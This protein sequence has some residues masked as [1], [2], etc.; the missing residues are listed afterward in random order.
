MDCTTLAKC[1]TGAGG[2]VS[3][4]DVSMRATTPESEQSRRFAELVESEP[5]KQ[6]LYVAQPVA[7]P[8]SNALT[9]TMSQFSSLDFSSFALNKAQALTQQPAGGSGPG[10]EYQNAAREAIAAQAEILRTVMMMEVM[11]TSK[12]GVTTLFQQQ[13]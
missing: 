13:G 6:T 5:Q 11:N 4:Q 10:S 3:P 1:A 2:A 7:E 9:H 12:Q 8:S